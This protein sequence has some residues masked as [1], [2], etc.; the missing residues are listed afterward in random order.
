MSIHSPFHTVGVSEITEV[1]QWTTQNWNASGVPG[2][3]TVNNYTHSLLSDERAPK[4]N[5]VPFKYNGRG[6]MLRYPTEYYRVFSASQYSPGTFSYLDSSGRQRRLQEGFGPGVD[7]SLFMDV[8][9]SGK[10]T[11]RAADFAR[12]VVKNRLKIQD[13]K[14]D[15]G[16]TMAES[17]KTIIGVAKTSLKLLR[18]FSAVRK[19]NFAK[20]ADI[21]G[22]RP[23]SIKSANKTAADYWLEYQYGWKPLMSDIHGGIELFK[24]GILRESQ[25]FTVK[26]TEIDNVP[27]K[28]R[29]RSY[30]CIGSYR[31]Q[32]TE[33]YICALKNADVARLSNLGL[34]NPAVVAWELVPFSFV[35]DWFLPVGNFLQSVTATLGYDFVMGYRTTHVLSTCS[36]MYNPTNTTG[37]SRTGS[38]PSI[39][40]S[41]DGFRRTPLVGFPQ[42]VL[43]FKNPFSSRHIANALALLISIRK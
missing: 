41:Y 9:A 6:P 39:Q 8:M 3:T 20:G 14:V 5:T 29:S 16:T 15:L 32:R 22:L 19:G 12:L 17:K 21:L 36:G 11:N 23:S 38:G 10:P 26:S 24:E 2:S 42:P 37:W 35:V 4:R 18:A 1:R 28:G 7:S 43:R 34:L 40:Q 33:K 31:V 27:F 13:Q 30:D 25:L